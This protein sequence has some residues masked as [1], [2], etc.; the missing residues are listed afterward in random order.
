MNDPK[1]LVQ[2]FTNE[3]HL[4][5]D[6]YPTSLPFIR[7][8]LPKTTLVGDGEVFQVIVAGGSRFQKAT[9]RKKGNELELLHSSDGDQPAFDTKRRFFEFLTSHLEPNVS[10]VGLNFANPL[11][12]TTRGD[13]LDGILTRGTKENDFAGLAG[14]AIGQEYEQYIKEKQDRDIK[15]A[16]AND[17]ICMLMSGLVRHSRGELAAGIVGTGLNFAIFLDDQTAINIE[18]SNFDKFERSD[19]GRAIDAASSQKG[20]S[21]YEKE[22]SGAYLH[23]HLNYLAKQ[24]GLGIPK[25]KS[26]KLIDTYAQDDDE[27]IAAAAKEVLEHSATLVAV[28]IAGLM[29]F[30]ERDLTFI[31][32]GSVYWKGYNYKETITKLVKE[33]CPDYTA[34][35]EKD[36]M[37][38]LYGAAKLVA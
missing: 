9:F 30:C 8:N 13:I 4:A 35:F 37:S 2:A 1:L 18:S 24:R 29:K 27:A 7:H 32:Q 6:G 20:T 25:L 3:L 34:T 17:T 23:Q 15:V 21:L 5:A 12:P 22:V 16:C 28:Q 26:T 33:L 31:M 36:P 14:K 38:D 19:A 11:A 10:V